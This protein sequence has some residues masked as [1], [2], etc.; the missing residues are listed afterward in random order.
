M[1]ASPSLH[2]DFAAALKNSFVVRLTNPDSEQYRNHIGEIGSQ[3]GSTGEPLSLQIPCKRRQHPTREPPAPVR[4][5]AFWAGA[6]RLTDA[7]D[8][9]HRPDPVRHT[10]RNKRNEVR[11]FARS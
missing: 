7:L 6:A 1:A 3:R 8:S 5:T 11:G 10:K 4:S 2:L 9:L